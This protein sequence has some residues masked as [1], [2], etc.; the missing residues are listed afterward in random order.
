M[1][2]REGGG[3]AASRRAPPK[4]EIKLR[5]CSFVILTRRECKLLF[6]AYPVVIHS[7]LVSSC[8]CEALLAHFEM[9]R[10]TSVHYYYFWGRLSLSKQIHHL[11]RQYINRACCRVLFLLLFKLKCFYIIHFL[12]YFYID[13]DE[14]TRFANSVRFKN[15]ERY[16]VINTQGS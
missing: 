11:L 8:H 7:L 1:G 15:S 12:Q 14:C 16:C 9:I 10:S 3:E 4:V 13:E 5:T 6:Q 2:G